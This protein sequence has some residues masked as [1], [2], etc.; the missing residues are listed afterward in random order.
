MF[1]HKTVMI[2]AH[3]IL[4]ICVPCL[5]ATG[6]A[7]PSSRFDRNWKRSW[8]RQDQFL[9]PDFEAYFPA[10]DEQAAK[11]LNRFLNDHQLRTRQPAEFI[12]AVRK[13]LRSSKQYKSRILSVLGNQLIWGQDAQHPDAIELMYQA[14]GSE[15]TRHDAMYYGLTVLKE[16]SYNVIRLMLQW[17]ELLGPEIQRRIPWGLK[18]YARPEDCQRWIEQ[19]LRQES[20]LG[21]S[22]TLAAIELYRQLTDRD[23]PEMERFSNLGRWVVCLEGIAWQAYADWTALEAGEYLEHEL[24]LPRDQLKSF[25]TRHEEAARLGVALVSGLVHKDALLVRLGNHPSLK[26][27]FVEPLND[28]VF[29]TRRLSEFAPFWP[30]QV[31]AA[32]P[33]YTTPTPGTYA[34]NSETYVAPDFHAYFPDDPLAG[35]ELDELL[36][37]DDFSHLTDRDILAVTQ[38]GLRRSQH[39]QRA[40]SWLAAAIG[41]PSSS[42]QTEIYYQ[43]CDPRGP[44]AIRYAAVYHGLGNW[45]AKHSNVLRLFARILASEPFDRS[46][47][48]NT[49]GRILWSVRNDQEEAGRLAEFISAELAQHTQLPFEVLVELDGAYRQLANRLPDARPMYR[50]RGTF[51]VI[52]RAKRAK[53]EQ[54]FQRRMREH[55]SD[56][57]QWLAGV[58]HTRQKQLG[59][60]AV[61]QGLEGVEWL[62]DQMSKSPDYTVD[63]AS[64]FTRKAVP[65][66]P[67]GRFPEIESHLHEDESRR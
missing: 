22:G 10:N 43:A 58:A 20:E 40:L 35:E 24:G 8:D 2:V 5:K 66:L 14:C 60:M 17:H 15:E 33:R 67:L 7:P 52:F 46:Q 30:H 31:Q 42:W 47:G 1:K 3:T 49:R 13:G 28:R 25:V 64:P 29:Q 27:R 9:L 4:V 59:G 12:E 53:S 26:L 34:W 32:K 36:K 61:V 44:A 23:P 6:T 62:V 11:E 16:P 56:S 21:E 41:W 37:L 39:P 19:A 55:F 63:F 51:L 65:E 45:Q 48:H 54:E 57:P 50:Q 38:K 18:T